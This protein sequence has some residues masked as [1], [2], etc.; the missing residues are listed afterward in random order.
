MGIEIVNCPLQRAENGLA[1][2]SRNALLTK[3][4]K[5][6][7]AV[8]YQTLE[9][10]NNS[11]TDWSVGE[12]ELYFKSKVEAVKDFKV[13]YFSIAPPSDLIPVSHLDS[14]KNYRI[15]VAVYAG[16]TRLIDTIELVRK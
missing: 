15:F 11:A 3:E 14:R 4:Q 9:Y 13:D 5:S 8:I 16:K 6:E 1:L 10:L 12:M 2:S 7:A